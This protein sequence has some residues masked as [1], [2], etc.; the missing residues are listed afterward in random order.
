MNVFQRIF[1]WDYFISKKSLKK[2]AKKFDLF[3]SKST[4]ILNWMIL[5]VK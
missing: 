3:S 4:K 1:E 2:A 5:S